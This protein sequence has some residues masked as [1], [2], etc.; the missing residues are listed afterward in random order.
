[1]HASTAN[2]AWHT[3]AAKRLL[4]SISAAHSS[5]DIPDGFICLIV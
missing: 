4:A 1:M 2:T 5:G 3:I